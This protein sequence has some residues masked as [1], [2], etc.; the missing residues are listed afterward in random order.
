M[1]L[2]KET[3]HV[4]NNEGKTIQPFYTHSDDKSTC[5]SSL[6]DDNS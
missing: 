3:R 6:S 2:E 4:E 1:K 5:S